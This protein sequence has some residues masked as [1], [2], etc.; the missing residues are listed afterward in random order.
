[1]ANYNVG[2][3][4][5]GVIANS[6]DTISSIDRLIK[7]L[8]KLDTLNKSVE[9]TFMT[10]NKLGNG[11]NKIQRLNFDYLQG[12]FVKVSES[13]KVLNDKLSGIENPKFG[14]TATQLNR[15]G[16]AFR[17][18]DKLKDFDFRK[19]YESFNSLNRI[20]TPFLDKLK[21]SETSLVAMNGVMASLKTKTI[22]KA[23]NELVKA[24]DNTDKLKTKLQDTDGVFKKAF[25]LSKLYF[26]YNYSKRFIGSLGKMITYASDYVEILNKFQVSFGDLYKDNLKLVNQTAQAFGF[27]TN[28]LLDYTATFNNMLKGLKGLSDNVSATI[29]QTMSNMAIDFASLFNVS[30]DR[31]M[32]AFQSAIAGNIRTIRSI[33]GFDVSETTIFSV[34]QNLGGT[35]TMRQLNQ[36]EKR[37]LRIIAIQQQM[38]QTGALGDYGRTIDTISN[39]IKI[40]KE[41]LIEVGKWIGMNLLTYIKPIIQYTNAI[42]LTIKE[43]AKALADVLQFTQEINYEEEF[44]SFGKSVDETTESV[45][46]L[47]SSLQNLPFDK[48]NILGSSQGNTNSVE[49][50][51]VEGDITN[52]LKSYNLLLDNVNYKAKDI[53]NSMLTWLGYTKTLDEETGEYIWKLNEGFTNLDKIKTIIISIV[54]IFVANAV[55]TKLSTLFTALK[56]APTVLGAIASPIGA[57]ALAIGIIVA[58]FYTLYNSSEDFRNSINT[59]LDNIKTNFAKIWDKLKSAFDFIKPALDFIWKI[60]SEISGIIV[61]E[62]LKKLEILTFLLNGDFKGAWSVVKNLIADTGNSI[63][64][65]FGQ[66]NWDAMISN[67]KASFS[68]IA[69][70][71]EN[72][73]F[74]P[75][76]DFFDTYI[77]KPFKSMINFIIEGANYIIKGLNKI[78]FDMPSWLGGYHVGI[79]IPEIPM[80]AKGGEITSPT[81]AMVGEYP[82]ANSNPEI[83][84]PQSI[85]RETFLEAIT[86]IVNAILGGNKEV[87]NAINDKDNN[88]YING[89]KVSESIY[90]D[91]SAVATRKGQIIFSK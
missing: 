33:S 17:Q 32:I 5:I 87:V 63:A 26:L 20:I 71:I 44:A 90:N 7:Q 66:D 67:M 21:Q 61:N 86:P 24:K 25:N 15:L 62:F 55:F 38:Q 9:N 85:M 16:N 53:S 68:N 91:L 14:D 83:V 54:S 13:T 56:A 8:N 28:T 30:I 74:K 2:N 47:A 36:L 84:A 29:S 1:M 42:L 6:K 64:R 22:T 80:L 23:S 48:L 57:I 60:I 70:W 59:T 3:I 11:L 4:E 72:N 78:S 19:M 65:I 31:A 73:I 49:G 77:I 58:G 40:M 81:M 41:Q 46:A 45:E 88:L 18:F 35:K 39:Q 69:G 52:A 76:N 82:N 75:I 34:Y 12:Q 43:M 89:R 10:I 37:L 27:S 51:S 50:L 79:D